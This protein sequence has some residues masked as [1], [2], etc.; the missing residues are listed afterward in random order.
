MHRIGSLKL[1][2][3][4]ILAPMAGVGDVAFRVLC[5]RYGAGLVCS[6]FLS[7]E[8]I[9]RFNAKA[10]DKTIIAEEE[11]PVSMQLFG[12]KCETILKAAKYLE[13]KVDVIDFNIGCPAD[14]ITRIECGAS[15]L[16]NPAKIAEIIKTLKQIKKPIT[17]KIRAG[18]DEKT[19]NAVQ[20]AKIAEQNGADMISV[21]ARTMKQGYS[22]KADWSI[23]RDVKE[24]VSIP[25]A[26]N[27]DI[28]DVQSAEKCL[29]ET[30]CDFLM[31]GRAAMKNPFVFKEINH[32]LKTGEVLKKSSKER[33]IFEY[34][35]L[36]KKFNIQFSR[37]LRHAMSFTAGIE[38]A[39]RTREILSRARSYEKIENILNP[40]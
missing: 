25:V 36:A 33:I 22:G 32:Y 24:N 2:N 15:L 27:G 26:A 17:V 18:I 8:A 19:I 3:N 5:R 34:L 1:E 30:K 31:I 10:I 23:I 39:A 20:I 16:K 29:K 28:I 12:N 4:L 21:H 37:A 40:P 11:R 35:E 6:D 7:A 14:K 13:D 38:N 9:V